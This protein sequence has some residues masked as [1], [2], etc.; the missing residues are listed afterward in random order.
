VSEKLG[1]AAL[2]GAREAWPEIELDAEQFAAHVEARCRKNGA[3]PEHLAD[4]YLAWA[5]ARGNAAA[6][7]IF[8]ERLLPKL[9]PAVRRLD[10]TAAFLQEVRQVL[11]VRLLVGAEHSPPRL[12]EYRGHGPLLAWLRVVAVRIALNLRRGEAP[13]S[14]T[15]EVLGELVASEPDPELRHLKTL[16]RA[17]FGAALRT[18]LS[19]LPER[20]RALLRL[21]Y[22]DGLTL[23]RIATLYQVHQSTVSRWLSSALEGVATAARRHLIQRLSLSPSSLESVARMVQSNLELSIRRIL[24]DAVP[25]SG[26]GTP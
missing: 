21:H 5:A 20:E 4:L 12:A 10:S 22:V 3:L 16:Y 24:G 9:D 26:P 8:D 17:E 18:A 14:S 13:V 15:E 23:A 6:L 19:A 1:Q 25:P 2:Q 7:R 11:R